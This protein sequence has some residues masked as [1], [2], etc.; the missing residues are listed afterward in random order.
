MTL[1]SGSSLFT[2]VQ[3]QVLLPAPAASCRPQSSGG[4]CKNPNFIT[5]RGSSDLSLLTA[6][7]ASCRPQYRVATAKIRTLSHDGEVRIYHHSLH[8]GSLESAMF[9]RLFSFKI[10][11]QTRKGSS[12]LMLRVC[13]FLFYVC[14]KLLKRYENCDI[15]Q[16]YGKLLKFT[17]NEE[18]KE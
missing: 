12:R 9:S 10:C 2:K 18:R 3:V 5:R 11:W 6:P 4:D 13:L 16:I 1:P 8:S 14:K 17:L 7:A 15:M